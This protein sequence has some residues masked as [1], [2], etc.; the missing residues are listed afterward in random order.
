M[1]GVQRDINSVL[2][3]ILNRL[4][5]IDRLDIDQLFTEIDALDARLDTVESHEYVEGANIFIQSTQ[6]TATGDWVWIDTTGIDLL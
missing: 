5:K 6:P 2:R 4:G 3:S 1:N